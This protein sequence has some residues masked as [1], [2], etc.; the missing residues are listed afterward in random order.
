MENPNNRERI[1]IRYDNIENAFV[2]LNQCATIIP[3]K[4][5][6]FLLIEYAKYYEIKGSLDKAIKAFEESVKLDGNNWKC[7]FEYIQFYMRS[8]NYTCAL[9]IVNRALNIHSNTG[10]L[11]A[12]LIQIKHTLA[13]TNE[14]LMEAYLTFKESSNRI[15]KSGEV[16]CEGARIVMNPKHPKYNLDKAK[17]YL[18]YAIHFTPQYGDSFIELMKLCILQCDKKSLKELKYKCIFSEPNYGNVWFFGKA[19]MN[20]T[21]Y[22]VWRRALN[23]ILSDVRINLQCKSITSG[24]MAFDR[25]ERIM[26]GDVRPNQEEKYKLLYGFEPIGS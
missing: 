4:Q 26:K 15:P 22:E 2:L 8:N 12:A 18:N 19:L 1:E 20:D 6:G 14:E 7:W 11:Y 9:D 23:M 24:I 5:Q 10:R 13:T 25:F 17:K 21:P 3:S 16:W